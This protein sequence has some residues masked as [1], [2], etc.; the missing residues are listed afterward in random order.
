MNHKTL[1][2]L[3]KIEP[4]Y[5]MW[6]HGL[7]F[8]FLVVMVI[9]DLTTRTAIL[10]LISILCFGFFA[11]RMRPWQVF[12]WV[13]VFAFTALFFL[14]RP[15]ASGVP[16]NSVV[17]YIRFGTIWV[18]GI[19][20]ML[21]S[22]NR[23]RNAES[24]LQTVTI[25]DKIPTPVIVS[26]CAGCVVFMNS[27]ALRLLDTTADAVRGASYFSFVSG[28]EKG[29]TVQKY[30]DFID[31]KQPLFHDMVLQLKTPFVRKTQATLIMIDGKN[32]K[33][34]ATVFSLNPENASAL[35]AE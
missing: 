12:G 31:S 13:A 24:F 5:A 9:L 11:H 19:G 21:L 25:L 28:E 35:V 27:N 32:Q 18:G 1:K 8:L 6:D 30:F 17:A 14:L 22:N 20:A 23:I 7:A 26:D 34:L 33:L 29:R 10:P 4:A 16:A 2:N 3:F 15:K